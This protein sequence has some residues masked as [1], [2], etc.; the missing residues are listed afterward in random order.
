MA[1][2]KS[3]VANS[4]SLRP[5]YTLFRLSLLPE[6]GVYLALLRPVVVRSTST[7]RSTRNSIRIPPH[8]RS[9]STGLPS[10]QLGIPSGHRRP[11]GGE[12]P[13][14]GIASGSGPEEVHS[15]GPEGVRSC[16]EEVR[17]TMD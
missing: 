14:V 15:T 4:L 6:Q 17:K 8:R 2:G 9:N 12:G 3:P 16:L 5:I 1:R 7:C 10:M 11:S 13:V